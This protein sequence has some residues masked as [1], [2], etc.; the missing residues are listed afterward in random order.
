MRC[1]GLLLLVLAVFTGCDSK[2]DP[3]N[4]VDVLPDELSAD[5]VPD[6]LKVS[7]TAGMRAITIKPPKINSI[8]LPRKDSMPEYAAKIIKPDAN[9]DYKI[10]KKIP[11]PNEGH[12]M[13]IIGKSDPATQCSHITQEGNIKYNNNSQR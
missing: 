9:I 3:N 4:L 11:D 8:Y 6:A 1:A 13:I 10:L 2:E 5:F 7:S 12:A